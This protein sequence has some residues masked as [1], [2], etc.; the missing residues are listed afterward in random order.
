M[1]LQRPTGAASDAE[2]RYRDRSTQIARVLWQN[3]EHGLD[4]AEIDAGAM[5]KGI[6]LL[7]IAPRNFKFVLGS[8]SDDDSQP[9]TLSEWGDQ[10]NL[11]AA[12]NASMYL[13][14]GITS[15]GYMKNER[16][17]NNQRIAS[18]F[19]AFF[20]SGPRERDLP[21]AAIIEKDNPEWRRLIDK[22][23]IVVQNYRMTN[24]QQK[25]LWN[26]G[27]PEYAISAVAEDMDG[28]ILFMHSREPVEAYQF[29]RT[30]LSLPLHIKSMMY[31]EG[32]SQAGLLLRTPQVRREIS[33]RNAASLLVTG[34][35]SARLPNVIGV[36]RKMPD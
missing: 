33:G 35:S 5:K 23:D 19:G 16:Q 25:I 24:S 15:T 34:N 8:I 22:Y 1:P 31:V 2:A 6:C 4:F 20:V 7:K 30:V 21:E 12:I 14:D 9:K 28:N 11:V 13:P 36:Q 10:K 32:G 26:P 3:L 17:F 29:A 27:G 18:R